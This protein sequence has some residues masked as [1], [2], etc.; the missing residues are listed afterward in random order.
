MVA[1]SFFAR[2][3]S[4]ISRRTEISVS[5]GSVRR[6]IRILQLSGTMFGCVPPEI[7]PTFTVAATLTLAIAIG[8]TTAVFGLVDGV[9]LARFPFPDPDHVLH[10]LESNP[11]SQL[12]ILPVAPPDY[13]DWRAQSKAFSAIAALDFGAVT[14]TGEPLK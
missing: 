8:A 5:P 7:V 11:T 6:S 12:P 3:N 14:V 10:V 1:A 13:L 2:S 9:L 4:V